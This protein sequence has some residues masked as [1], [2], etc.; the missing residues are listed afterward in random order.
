VNRN[1][2]GNIGSGRYRH[3]P[4]SQHLLVAVVALQLSYGLALPSVLVLGIDSEAILARSPRQRG[5]WYGEQ[6]LV[7][8]LRGWRPIDAEREFLHSIA[9][10]GHIF[11]DKEDK[12]DVKEEPLGRPSVFSS[13]TFRATDNLPV[14][15][16]IS[17]RSRV[18][19]IHNGC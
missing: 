8:N 17:I 3:T 9:E 16:F 13:S 18:L 15:L 2:S 7:T 5:V 19:G 14:L 1:S 6:L 4:R 10:S 11:G 12:D